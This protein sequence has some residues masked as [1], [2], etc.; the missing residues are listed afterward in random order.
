[1]SDNRGSSESLGTISNS[2]SRCSS[3]SG[4][5]RGGSRRESGRGCGRGNERHIARGREG[6]VSRGSEGSEHGVGV[7]KHT[8]GEPLG[9]VFD[10]TDRPPRRDRLSRDNPKRDS[11]N[12]QIKCE[13]WMGTHCSK[14]GLMAS[15]I[16]QNP[17]V[18]GSWQ[19]EKLHSALF[20]F[21]S[22]LFT[23]S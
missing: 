17:P 6:P 23:V 21:G 5:R 18:L 3:C 12:H 11:I 19:L 15:C 7:H 20:L 8:R 1:M 10:G 4:G 16:R 14:H 9:A 22:P 13:S 2:S